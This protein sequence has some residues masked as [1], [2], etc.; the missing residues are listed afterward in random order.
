MNETGVEQRC[1]NRE[2]GIIPD[3]VGKKEGRQKLMQTGRSDKR[4][5][6]IQGFGRKKEMNIEQRVLYYWSVGYILRNV[7]FSLAMSDL[8]GVL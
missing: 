8:M 4:N 1:R 6:R 5:E 7:C 2:W 3:R